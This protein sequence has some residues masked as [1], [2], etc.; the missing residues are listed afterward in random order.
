MTK[1]GFEELAAAQ[2]RLIDNLAAAISKEL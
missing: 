1:D 2:S